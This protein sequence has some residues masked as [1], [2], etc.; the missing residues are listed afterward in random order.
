MD[1]Y[2][3]NR[4]SGLTKKTGKNNFFQNNFFPFPNEPEEIGREQPTIH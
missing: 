1:C 2:N 4:V 3:Q